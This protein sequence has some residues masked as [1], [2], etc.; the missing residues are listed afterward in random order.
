M[1]VRFDTYTKSAGEALAAFDTLS[2]VTD[3]LTLSLSNWSGKTFNLH[4]EIKST[5]VDILEQQCSSDKWNED[6][7]EL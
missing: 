4:G 5:D 2:S 3:N 6:A 1:K 7:S